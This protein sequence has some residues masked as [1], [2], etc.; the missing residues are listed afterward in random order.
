MN[1]RFF[2]LTVARYLTRSVACGSSAADATGKAKEVG[3]VTVDLLTAGTTSGAISSWYRSS[4]SPSEYRTWNNVFACAANRTTL[5]WERDYWQ[6]ADW[7]CQ[8]VDVTQIPQDQ[9]QKNV[10]PVAYLAVT[11]FLNICGNHFAAEPL[12]CVEDDV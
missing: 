9:H 1:E 3:A 7:C 12:A 4:S 10:H 2:C 11:C 6:Y 8:H 5:I